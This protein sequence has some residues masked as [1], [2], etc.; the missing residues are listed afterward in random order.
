MRLMLPLTFGAL[1]QHLLW[2]VLYVGPDLMLPLTSAFAAAAG[3]VL[4]FWHRVV[5]VLRTGWQ[6][7]F[8]RNKPPRG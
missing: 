5:G 4:M 2:I 3:L 7:L 6:M 1:D 8:D